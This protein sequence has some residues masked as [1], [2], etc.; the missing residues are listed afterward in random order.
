MGVIFGPNNLHLSVVGGDRMGNVHVGLGTNGEVR[1][2][3]VWGCLGGGYVG[4]QGGNG[5]ID[6]Q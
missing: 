1:Y 4:Q 6:H 3:A 5:V 2:V